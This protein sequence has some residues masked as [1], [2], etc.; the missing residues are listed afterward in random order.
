MA[1]THAP[2][3]TAG[4]ILRTEGLSVSY[5]DRRA[6]RHVSMS[7]PE[8]SVVALIGPTGGGKTTLLRSFNRMTELRRGAQHEGAILLAGQDIHAEGVD[9]EAVRRRVGMVFDRPNLFPTTVFENLA[10]GLRIHGL[11]RELQSR[12]EQVLRRIGMWDEVADRLHDPASTLSRGQQQRLC[13]ARSLAV[14]PDVLLMD[15]PTSDLDPVAGARIE[16]LVYEIRED[17]TVVIATHSLQEAARVSDFTAFLYMGELVEYGSTDAI[18]TNP[19][20]ERT[21]AYVTGRFG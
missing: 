14:E 11:K 4:G 3:D 7:V 18:F 17:V 21:E 15:E 13:I 1:L 9:P 5:G 10:F 2:L 19:L 16:E 6:L 20:E 8:G 12:V